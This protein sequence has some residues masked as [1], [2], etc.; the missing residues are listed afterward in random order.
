MDAARLTSIPLFADLPA[1]EIASISTFSEER[2]VPDGTRIVREGDFSDQLSVIEEGT[3][4]VRH[5]DEVVAS[6][7]PGD[8]FGEAGV[9]G[10]SMRNAD[11][12]ATSPLRLVTLTHWDVKR[13]PTAA[14]RM[15]ELA[16]RRAAAGS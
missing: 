2:S 16:E 13:V 8:V 7:G 5:G 10:R 11:V 4:E 9:L 1:D 15:R 12:V 3:A 6:L 14:Q